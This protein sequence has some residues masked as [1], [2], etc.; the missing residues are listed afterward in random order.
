MVNYFELYALPVSFHPHTANVKFKFYEL[1]R[2]WHPDRFAQS[3]DATRAEALRMAAL[4]NDAYKTLSNP[5][6]LMAYILKLYGMLEEEEKYNLPPDFLME[7]M[8]LNELISEYELDPTNEEAR[9]EATEAI[10]SEFREWDL[11]VAP[12]TRRFNEGEHTP[13]LLSEIKD[14]Y[15]RRKYLLRIQERIATFA[16]PK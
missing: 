7:M 11:E 16:T 15:F 5:D 6:A 12:L 1:S 9:S 10:E 3:D 2:T 14:Y 13:A 4:N 8:E